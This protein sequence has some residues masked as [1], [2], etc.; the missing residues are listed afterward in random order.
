MWK[1]G[2]GFHWFEPPIIKKDTCRNIGVFYC[3]IMEWG[4]YMKKNNIEKNTSRM[5]ILLSVVLM[6][7]GIS[8]S[9]IFRIIP[10]GDQLVI[11][12]YFNFAGSFAGASIGALISMFVLYVTVNQTKEI[13]K[14]NSVQFKISN[15]NEELKDLQS[16][17]LMYIRFEKILLSGGCRLLLNENAHEIIKVEDVKYMIELM[18]EIQLEIMKEYGKIGKEKMISKEDEAIQVTNEIFKI[19]KNIVKTIE[20][21][22]RDVQTMKSLLNEYKEK[23]EVLND[24]RIDQVS[25]VGEDIKIQ[26]NKKYT[27]LQAGKDIQI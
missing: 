21:G 22:N 10:Y 9:I 18:L 17:F 20:K 6:I 12:D 4:D 8:I 19:G 3:I 23:Y 1:R 2:Q 14:E 16:K 25:M 11:E 27:L 15:I 7:I 13:Q 24:I 5:F 26:S